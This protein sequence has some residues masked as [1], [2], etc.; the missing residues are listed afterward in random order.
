MSENTDNTSTVKGERN[1]PV[2][3]KH[4][5]VKTHMTDTSMSHEEHVIV[6]TVKNTEEYIQVY[7]KIISAL[8]DIGN[9]PV[10][11]ALWLATQE[12]VRVFQLTQVVKTPDGRTISKKYKF[13]AIQ[14]V[15]TYEI[16]A[17]RLGVNVRTITRH[18]VELKKAGLLLELD[19][20]IKIL[21]P[22]YFWKTA[23]NERKDTIHILIRMQGSE[24]VDNEVEGTVILEEVEI[25]PTPSN[26]EI[27]IPVK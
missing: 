9:A 3:E 22:E 7:S 1:M 12:P 6:R 11:T 25:L 5:L 26:L 10:K 17:K 13:K 20:S 21:N 8:N 24:P 23:T 2:V 15:D 19:K 27:R 18:M 4:S 16:L 14:I